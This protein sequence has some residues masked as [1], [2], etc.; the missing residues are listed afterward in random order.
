MICAI[1]RPGFLT[2][3]VGAGDELENLQ[4]HGDCG[5]K[6]PDV[7]EVMGEVA[8]DWFGGVH[9]PLLFEGGC[10]RPAAIVWVWCLG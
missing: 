5:E 1:R 8:G 9:R 10:Q 6:A 4:V 3:L 7:G 2:R